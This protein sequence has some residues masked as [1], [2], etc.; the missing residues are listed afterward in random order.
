MWNSIKELR[1]YKWFLETITMEW[2]NQ[3]TKVIESE[4]MNKECQKSNHENRF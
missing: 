3:I 2:T 4:A 1:D